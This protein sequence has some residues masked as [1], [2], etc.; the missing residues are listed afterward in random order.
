VAT[1]LDQSAPEEGYARMPG[2]LRREDELIRVFATRDRSQAARFLDAVA[3]TVAAART[4][5]GDFAGET[6]AA[7]SVCTELRGN[8]ARLMI[9]SRGH[10][11]VAE[12]AVELALRIRALADAPRE[13]VW[14][15]G[16]GDR[17]TGDVINGVQHPPP[18]GHVGV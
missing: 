6:S 17:G 2:W 10:G 15:T 1:S 16:A 13:P 5:P 3:N 11:G 18:G 4:Q 7:L 9:S 8:A 14:A 12:D